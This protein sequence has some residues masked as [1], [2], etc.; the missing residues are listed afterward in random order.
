MISLVQ[1]L[2]KQNYTG[3][4]RPL[5]L[6]KSLE[7]NKKNPL[8]FGT[9]FSIFAVILLIGISPVATDN[10]ETTGYSDGT[11]LKGHFT[12]T[13]AD[14]NGNII[15]VIQTDNL[16]V[17]EGMECTADLVF[18]TTSCVAEAVFQFLALGT[19]TVAPVDANLA[20]GTESGTCARVQDA[21]PAID[22]SVTGQRAVT[23]SSLFSGGTCE[24]QAFGETGLFDASSTGNMLARS[25]I[26][27]TITLGVGDTLTID[28]TITI[29]NT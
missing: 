13:H 23:V 22:V 20:L 4:N 26:T 10:F 18:G 7:S 2:P 27:P 5:F 17:N 14:P 25:L 29:N 11:I 28:Y 15:Q 16:V 12:F 8:I 19:G 9:G 21:T 1:E 6:I 24:A 3:L